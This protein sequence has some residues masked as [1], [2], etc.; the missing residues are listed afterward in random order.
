MILAFVNIHGSVHSLPG[1][2][3]CFNV[4]VINDMAL[5]AIEKQ[6]PDI[7]KGMFE[8]LYPDFSFMSLD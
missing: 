4:M 5:K 3:L 2:F 8:T 7:K 1:P 6:T